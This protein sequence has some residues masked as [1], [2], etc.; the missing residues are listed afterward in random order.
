MNTVRPSSGGIGALVVALL[1]LPVACYPNPDDLRVAHG[2]GGSSGGASGGSSGTGGG[3]AGISGGMGGSGPPGTGGRVGAGGSGGAGPNQC[4]APACGGN[5]V[6]AWTFVS[7][8]SLLARGD[9][10]DVIDASG[11][12]R[13]ETL[14]FNANGTYSMVVT[15][16]GTFMLD[17]PA[18]CLGGATCADFQAGLAAETTVF[19][20]ASCST[21][22]TGCHCSMGALGRQ[23]TDTGTYTASGTSATTTSSAGTVT[24]ITYCVIGSSLRLIY[25]DSTPAMLDESVFTK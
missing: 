3:G 2:A 17:A 19:S 5:L 7:D 9:C 10:G 13:S 14:T 16:T 4:G 1:V 22:T 18:A 11:V 8:C 23:Q 21:T 15:D 20:S 24:V 25:A 12:H 6:G